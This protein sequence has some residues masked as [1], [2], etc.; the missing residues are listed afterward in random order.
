[1]VIVGCFRNGDTEIHN[2]LCQRLSPLGFLARAGNCRESRRRRCL[3][4]FFASS[5]N[6]DSDR[7]GCRSYCVAQ[8]AM[9][10]LIIE[11]AMPQHDALQMVCIKRQLPNL[12]RIGATEFLREL[13]AENCN[14]I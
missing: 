3:R 4:Q 9:C 8:P 7:L 5:A 6:S 14:H 1:M 12:D 10:R 2:Q 11:P 13:A